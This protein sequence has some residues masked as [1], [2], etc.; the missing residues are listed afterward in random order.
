MMDCSQFLDGYS[1]FRDGVLGEAERAEYQQHLG[2]CASCG[3]Y[4]RVIQRGVTIFRDLPGVEPSSDFMPRLQHRL[5]HVEDE[6][7][8]SGHRTSGASSSLLLAIAAA[9]A[10]VAWA[11]ALRVRPPVVLRLAP[12]AAGAPKRAPEVPLLFRSG[13][14]LA[15]PAYAVPSAAGVAPVRPDVWDDRVHRGPAYP[16]LFEYTPLGAAAGPVRTAGHH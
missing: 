15:A 7:R 16:L 8:A 5:Y 2:T 3:R 12:V 10:L 9:I 11:P 4:D 14:L 13:P 1:E 6:M